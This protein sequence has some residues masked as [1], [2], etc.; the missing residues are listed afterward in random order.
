MIIFKSLPVSIDFS[1]KL[2]II[3]QASGGLAH[4]T[5]YKCLF[6]KFSNFSLNFRENFDRTLKNFQKIAKFPWKFS[7][8]CKIFIDFLNFLKPLS[9]KKRLN[10]LFLLCKKVLPLLPV[11]P[12][13]TRE[14]L[15]KLLVC[16]I[17]M[18][19]FEAVII[20]Q[21]SLNNSRNMKILSQWANTCLTC[22]F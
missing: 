22:R 11:P 4:Q 2:L 14:I 17:T 8:N 10:F 20:W 18:K 12:P 3:S 15:D 16:I 7:K 19:D 6:P 5:S 1:T 13:P 21:L 9:L